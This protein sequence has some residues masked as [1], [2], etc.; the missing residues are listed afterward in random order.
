VSKKF[1]VYVWDGS[2]PISATNVWEWSRIK[3][4]GLTSWEVRGFDVDQMFPLGQKLL[5]IGVRKDV[6]SIVFICTLR[7]SRVF[8]TI[9]GVGEQIYW[10]LTGRNYKL[11]LHS[12]WFSHCRSYHT[13]PPQVFSLVVATRFLATDLSQDLSLQ[14]TMKSSCRFLFNRLGLS[15]LQN[16]TQFS[17]SNSLIF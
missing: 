8:V 16:W 17:N 2:K 15:T 4:E 13:E 12:C 14:I 11:V 1:A 10:P 9:D 5:R 7:V 6:L 3:T